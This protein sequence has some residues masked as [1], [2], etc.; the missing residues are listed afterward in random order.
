MGLQA[1][2]GRGRRSSESGRRWRSSES[3]RRRRWSVEEALPVRHEG[4]V[5]PLG[6]RERV[7]IIRESGRTARAATLSLRFV[8][9][10]KLFLCRFCLNFP[11]I[12]LGLHIPETSLG[13]QEIRF[14]FCSFSSSV[15]QC[16]VSIS[17]RRSRMR[18]MPGGHP[19][20]MTPYQFVFPRKGFREERVNGLLGVVSEL[21]HLA[22]GVLFN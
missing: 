18:L 12:R 5:D 2:R 13:G 9:S 15:F 22:F 11:M 3:G 19:S 21:L 1:R 20:L 17:K 14:R 6:E 10:K 7:L 8:S 4:G 16:L